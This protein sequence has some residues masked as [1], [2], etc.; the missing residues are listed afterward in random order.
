MHKYEAYDLPSNRTIIKMHCGSC[1]Y[2]ASIKDGNVNDF[3]SSN[4]FTLEFSLVSGDSGKFSG[5]K[6]EIQKA[7]DKYKWR[8]IDRNTY[9]EEQRHRQI[10]N[11]IEILKY[12]YQ[13]EFKEN[14]YKPYEI[15]VDN[16]IWMK[17]RYG[18][19]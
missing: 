14:A 1:G 12:G 7:I 17:I 3:T 19:W 5:T 6:E 11:C 18:V 9:S 13:F 10:A 4:R 15:T 8:G 16:G 2:W